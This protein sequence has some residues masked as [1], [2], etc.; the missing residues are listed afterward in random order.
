MYLSLV[1]STSSKFSVFCMASSF[2]FKDIVNQVLVKS[3][4]VKSLNQAEGGWFDIH[5]YMC[6]MREHRG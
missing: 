4:L 1:K 6:L 3:E 2:L 5:S